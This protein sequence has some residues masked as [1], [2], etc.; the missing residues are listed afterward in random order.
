V[1]RWFTVGLVSLLVGILALPDTARARAD[2]GKKHAL[3]VGV[4]D[5]VSGKFE[6]LRYTEN[7][8]EDLARVLGDTAGFHVRVLSSTRGKRKAS[9]APTAVNIRAAL[10]KL[11]ADRGRNDTVLV[12]LSGHGIQSKI[13]EKEDNFF[14]PADAQLND[15]RRLVSLSQLVKDLD[16]CGAV[17]G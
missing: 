9:D 14:C 2:E 1:G 5:Y 4:R 16:D 13:K 11:L 7:D 12:A 17:R 15:N 6:P 8:V 10:G 3:L